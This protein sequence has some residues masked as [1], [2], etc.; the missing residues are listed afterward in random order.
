MAR[1]QQLPPTY[2]DRRRVEQP[3]PNEEFNDQTDESQRS[4]D[5]DGDGDEVDDNNE[6]EQIIADLLMTDDTED[7]L[8]SNVK[9]EHL[10]EIEINASDRSE[11]NELLGD[12]EPSNTDISSVSFN[13]ENATEKSDDRLINMDEVVNG[14]RLPIDAIQYIDNANGHVSGESTRSADDVV[15]V[16][17]AVET[18]NAKEKAV[19]TIQQVDVGYDYDAHQVNS[20]NVTNEPSCSSS[21]SLCVEA[22]ELD[23]LSDSDDD[24]KIC[25]EY[26]SLPMPKPMASMPDHLLKQEND[27]ISGSLPFK[28]TVS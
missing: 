26:R 16:L 28:I 11:V 5:G 15:G 9:I 23:D 10:K 7:P 20:D 22:T 2:N 13:P 8:D 12:A 3:I 25:S 17:S 1:R 14:S 6:Q 19:D 21:K 18:A 27:D 4:N 24:V